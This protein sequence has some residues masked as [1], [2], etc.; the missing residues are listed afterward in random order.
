MKMCPY[1]WP[2]TNSCV[3]INFSLPIVLDENQ[4]EWSGYQLTAENLEIMWS[5][6]A[7]QYLGLIGLKPYEKPDDDFMLLMWTLIIGGVT[8]FFAVVLFIIRYLMISLTR[9]DKCVFV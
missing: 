2:N 9:K 3:W 4:T 1:Y 5:T 8:I 6:Y 7:E